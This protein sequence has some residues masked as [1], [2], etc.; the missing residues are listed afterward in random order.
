[1][2]KSTVVNTTAERAKGQPA[3]VAEDV[4]SVE[5]FQIMDEKYNPYVAKIDDSVSCVPVLS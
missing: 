3:A 2:H 4:A 5:T 1:M